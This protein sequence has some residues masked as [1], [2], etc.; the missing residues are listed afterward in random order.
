MLS[1]ILEYVD[2][3]LIACQTQDLAKVKNGISNVFECIDKGPL[4][5]FLGME[6]EREGDLGAISLGHSQYIKDLLG[7]HGSE[8]CTMAKTPLD[9]GFQI[10]CTSDQCKNVEPAVY[11]SVIGELVWLTITTSPDILHSVS[12]HMFRYFSAPV[13]MKHINSAVNLSLDLWLQT[14]QVIGLTGSL[15]LHSEKQRSVAWRLAVLKRRRLW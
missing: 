15:T 2:D 7:T 5:H 6:I 9:V 8:N 3:I 4:N 1:L 11:Q 10:D 12:E 13:D 14:G